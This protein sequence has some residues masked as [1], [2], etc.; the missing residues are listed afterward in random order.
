MYRLLGRRTVSAIVAGVPNVMLTTTGAKTGRQRTV[1]LVGVPVDGGI[2]VIG[3][4]W[5]SPTAPGWSYN[6]DHDPQA[7]VERHGERTPVVARRLPE[8]PEY[9][10]ALVT[11]S[12]DRP[13]ANVIKRSAD[14]ARGDHRRYTA[15]RCPIRTTVTITSSSSMR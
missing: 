4:R 5:G 1:P 12:R 13:R 3:T 7:V 11:S 2:A 15:P 10:A 8:G 6:L 14:R 9:E